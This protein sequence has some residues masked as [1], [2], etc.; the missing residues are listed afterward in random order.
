MVVFPL[1]RCRFLVILLMTVVDSS[2]G[3]VFL[4]DDSL[5]DV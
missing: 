2:A 3:W 1:D 5:I 4:N